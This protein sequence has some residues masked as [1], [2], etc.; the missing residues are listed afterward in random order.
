MTDH[1]VATPE[2]W[3]QARK[4]LL[5]EEK[6]FTRARDALERQAARAAVGENRQ[7]LSRSR[8]LTAR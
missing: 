1:A 2:E 6:A 5:A 7:A 4:A 8:V 3:L